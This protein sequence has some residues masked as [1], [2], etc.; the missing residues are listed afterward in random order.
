MTTIYSGDKGAGH[1]GEGICEMERMFVLPG[2]TA[3]AW[4]P[5]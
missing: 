3:G 4:A 5:G 1:L 2:I